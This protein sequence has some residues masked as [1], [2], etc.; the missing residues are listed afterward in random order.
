[1]IRECR[2]TMVPTKSTG[3]REGGSF[4]SANQVGLGGWVEEELVEDGSLRYQFVTTQKD[5]TESANNK[6]R[7]EKK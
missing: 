6:R 5:R 2:S 1:M 4:R 3:I 7:T